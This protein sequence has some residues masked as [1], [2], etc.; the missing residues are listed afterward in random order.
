MSHICSVT[1]HLKKPNRLG[2]LKKHGLLESP[3]FLFY[4][5]LNNPLAHIYIY[6]VTPL[7]ITQPTACM[8]ES[9]GSLPLGL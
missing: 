9:N 3:H 6:R 2:F 5:F 7:P 8:V 4:L 1:I